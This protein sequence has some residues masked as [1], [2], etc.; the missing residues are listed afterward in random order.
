M[1]GKRGYQVRCMV[2]TMQ[3]AAQCVT[4]DMPLQE[5]SKEE[6][7]D[8]HLTGVQAVKAGPAGA[9]SATHAGA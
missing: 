8:A 2:M 7:F 1:A 9:G 3:Q 5:Y 4:V 6:Y